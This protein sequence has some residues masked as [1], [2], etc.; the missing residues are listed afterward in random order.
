MSG[1]LYAQDRLQEKMVE[2]AINT[3]IIHKQP[4]TT[5]K[6]AFG[7]LDDFKD[8]L[9]EEKIIAWNENI[10]SYWNNELSIITFCSRNEKMLLNMHNR[11]I[12]IK[13]NDLHIIL[14]MSNIDFVETEVKEFDL[15]SLIGIAKEI[16]IHNN[17]LTAI[18]EYYDDKEFKVFQQA[19]NLERIE[20]KHC[21]FSVDNLNNLFDGC[22]NLKEVILDDIEIIELN[23][24]SDFGIIHLFG[25]CYK[26]EEV[27]ITALLKYDDYIESITGLFYECSS[28]KE[29]KGLEN[30]K[31]RN[32]KYAS[33]M[34]SGCYSLKKIDL[35]NAEFTK[36]YEAECMF[37]DCCRVEYIDMRKAVFGKLIN[38]LDMFDKSNSLK[39]LHIENMGKDKELSFNILEMFT[40]LS[41]NC[42]IYIDNK[43]KLNQFETIQ[44]EDELERIIEEEQSE[45]L[46]KHKDLF[47]LHLT[48]TDD[49]LVEM[50]NFIRYKGS[51]EK[52]YN[53]EKV[54]EQTKFIVMEA[55]D[56][57][58][59]NFIIKQNFFGKSVIYLGNA[60]VSGDENEEIIIIVSNKIEIAH[61][62][63]LSLKDN[64]DNFKFI[65][66]NR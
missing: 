40:Y 14:D 58:I 35:S 19:D 6:I 46:L 24:L 34:F 21:G 59:E 15:A 65:G 37:S 5:L 56:K 3:V 61:D 39:E 51:S 50:N 33:S 38:T 36:L 44:S 42:K 11:V 32:V 53:F 41:E 27:D 12:Y 1:I 47:D 49:Y 17:T 57:E 26:L 4:K 30:F 54:L 55:T 60:Y 29:I 18:T 28:L 45:K 23:Q 2:E 13:K 9:D 16:V 7:C 31:F 64:K 22:S 8:K 43:I 25:S 66:H 52:C 63:K 48:L 10:V 20:I 62:L